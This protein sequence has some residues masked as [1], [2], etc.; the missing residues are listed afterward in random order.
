MSR[1]DI[2]E[3]ESYNF[4]K[5]KNEFTNAKKGEKTNSENRANNWKILKQISFEI[6]EP[7]KN[8]NRWKPKPIN[9]YLRSHLKNQLRDE[10]DFYY[11]AKSRIRQ[12]LG[13]IKENPPKK[14]ITRGWRTWRSSASSYSLNPIDLFWSKWYQKKKKG[15]KT[16]DYFFPTP[17]LSNFK[18][19]YATLRA[20][21]KFTDY[22]VNIRYGYFLKL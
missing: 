15:L 20:K 3:P 16:R 19:F 12:Q 7:H 13:E 18:F 2:V 8:K 10:Y 6:S 21:G 11:W 5:K 4:E 1:F 17:E 22:S 9:P 14:T